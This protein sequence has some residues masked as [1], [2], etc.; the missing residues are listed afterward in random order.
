M[1]A[2]RWCLGLAYVFP[3]LCRLAYRCAL[4]NTGRPPGYDEEFGAILRKGCGK[5]GLLKTTSDRAD[6]EAALTAYLRG[7]K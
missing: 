4:W 3:D 6:F 1:Y 2:I 7:R 5:L